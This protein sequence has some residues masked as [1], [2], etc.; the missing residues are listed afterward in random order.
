MSNVLSQLAPFNEHRFNE[1]MAFFAA[2][3]GGT[4]SQYDL[5]KLHVLTDVFHVLRH[6]KPVIG[7]ELQAWDLGPVAPRAYNLVKRWSYT[8]DE[9]EEQPE[10][11]RV[12]P[13]QGKRIDYTVAK[14]A[15]LDDF[16]DAEMETMLKAWHIF[17]KMSWSQREDYFHKDS[18]LGKAW[19]AARSESREEISWD[20]IIDEYAAETRMPSEQAAVIKRAIRF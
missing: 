1:C 2:R 14:Q 10:Y 6:G 15:D 11:F 19:L 13:G 4:L 5:V 20:Q 7:G 12:T 9:T 16:S 17:S 3:A 8:A 18:F